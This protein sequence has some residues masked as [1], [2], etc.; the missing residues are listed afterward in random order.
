[1]PAI[2][3]RKT[4][5]VGVLWAVSLQLVGAQSTKSADGL[6]HGDSAPTKAASPVV[7]FEIGCKNLEK[8]TSFYREIFSWNVKPAGPSNKVAAGQ[9]GIAGQITALGEEPYHYVTVYISVNKIEDYL[10]RI[11]KLGGKQ[12]VGPIEIPSGRFAWFLDPEGNQVGLMDKNP[13]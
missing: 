9:D 12:I 1:M 6:S 5:F 7:Y 4:A 2:D 13:Q 11:E 3:L 8:T 10:A